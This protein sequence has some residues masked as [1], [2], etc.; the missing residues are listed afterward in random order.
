MKIQRAN[1]KGATATMT[2]TMTNKAFSIILGK[3]PLV[4]ISGFQAVLEASQVKSPK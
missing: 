3:G 4:S 1:R 2:A